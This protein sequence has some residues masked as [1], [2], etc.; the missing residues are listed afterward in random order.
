MDF[1]RVWVG[2]SGA[3]IGSDTILVWFTAVFLFKNLLF[4]LQ[5]LALSYFTLRMKRC[6]LMVNARMCASQPLA[7]SYP[8]PPAPGA[9]GR[10]G[11]AGWN[12]CEI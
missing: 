1:G 2:L 5:P 3:S 8:G 7:H 11:R 6:R 9:L 10:P 12:R 4:A